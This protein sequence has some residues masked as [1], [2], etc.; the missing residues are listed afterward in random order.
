M[1]LKQMRYL[2]AIAQCQSITSAAQMFYISQA[3]L[4]E[5]LREV[6]REYGFKVFKRSNRVVS[7]TPEG[8]E[9]IS[10]VRRVVQQDDL[11]ADRFS[12]GS[13]RGTIQHLTVSSQRYSF[14]VE[15]IARLMA[16]DPDNAFSFTLRETDTEA[17]FSDVRSME[18]DIGILCV[19][20]QNE[21]VVKR[22][23]DRAGLGFKTLVETVPSA[24]VSETHPL[25]VRKTVHVDDLAPF[26]RI[27]FE[28]RN[29]ASA[30][31]YE[32]PL[33]EA[34]R[35]GTVQVRDRGSMVSFLNLT[36]AYAIGSGFS[37]EGMD[38]GTVSVPIATDERMQIGYL[39]NPRATRKDMVNQLI[40]ELEKLALDAKSTRRR[41]ANRF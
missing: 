7:P 32:D 13:A 16:A 41:A 8:L 2:L 20:S 34:P 35:T 23:I 24:V 18:S 14:V 38:K 21:T 19:T 10:M 27:L 11:I 31:Y 12:K 1:T 17:I 9:L 36:D 26:P 4:S 22:E 3:S 37:A 40:E 30:Y 15:A 33:P 6:E 5:A 39:L 29:G 28:Q 25:A